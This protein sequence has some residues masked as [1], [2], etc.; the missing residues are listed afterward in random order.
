MSNLS[1][2]LDL[3]C[4]LSKET[5]IAESGGLFSASAHDVFGIVRDDVLVGITM[6][7]SRAVQMIKQMGGGESPV[8]QIHE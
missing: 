2:A 5:V 6:N 8:G 7:R 1:A 3:A 4:R